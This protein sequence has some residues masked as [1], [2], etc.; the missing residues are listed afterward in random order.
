MYYNDVKAPIKCYY[1]TIPI[2]ISK[3]IFHSAFTHL[4]QNYYYVIWNLKENKQM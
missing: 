3:S 1:Y 4:H 2:L